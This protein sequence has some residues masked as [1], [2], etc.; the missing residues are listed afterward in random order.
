MVESHVS[1]EQWQTKTFA[2]LLFQKSAG[3]IGH[4]GRP[5]PIVFSRAVSWHQ[6]YRQEVNQVLELWF[7]FHQKFVSHQKK[8]MV[9][10]WITLRR[11]PITQINHKFWHVFHWKEQLI[12]PTS[13]RSKTPMLRS[14]PG[15]AK[16]LVIGIPFRNCTSNPSPPYPMSPVP[17]PIQRIH[18]QSIRMNKYTV[19][20]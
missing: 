3:T 15:A 13:I 18:S 5:H 20:T 4:L 12:N 16:P 2:T 11:L 9:K 7:V 1:L 19:S 17:V 14:L 8:Q 6:H 10:Q